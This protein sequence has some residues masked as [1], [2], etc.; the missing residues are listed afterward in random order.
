MGRVVLVTGVS[1]YLGSR[2][3][4]ILASEPHIERVIGVDVVPP[5]VPI[6]GIDFIRA[7]IRNPV[8]AKVMGEAQVDTVVHMGVIATPKQAGGRSTMKE[9]NVIGS[10]QLLAA[11]Q[12]T[13]SLQSIVVKSSSGVYG[14]GPRDP[15]LFT[16]DMEPQHAPA[17]GWPKDSSEVEG[18]VRGFARRRPEVAVTTFRFANF[19]GGEIDTAMSAYFSLPVIPTVLGYDARIQ[20]LHVDDGLEVLRRA[21]R[22]Q[23]VG[24]FNVAGAGVM[25]L[26]QAIRH[27][28]RPRIALPE[29]L[30]TPVGRSLSKAGLLDFSSEQ[31]R[32]ITFGRVLDTSLVAQTFAFTPKYT[33]EEA[34]AAFLARGERV[35]N[36]A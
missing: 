16:E 19:L 31:V 15:A 23:H 34:F 18:Y 4:E 35:S 30:L 7:D 22:D 3:A 26:S 9:I 29:F 1:R 28:G 21:V 10:M 14:C 27:T 6:P 13:P 17:S 32:F 36:V 12:K 24:T 25:T 8:I 2:I 33:S 5:A 11:C 20:F